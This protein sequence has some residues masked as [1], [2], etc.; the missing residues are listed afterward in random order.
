MTPSMRPGT[1]F[2]FAIAA[3]V[4]ASA[5]TPVETQGPQQRQASTAPMA[6]ADARTLL[7]QYCSTCHSDR[8]KAG[9]LLLTTLDVAQ[10][11]HDPEAWEK[12]SVRSG[13]E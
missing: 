10:V 3:C 2:T 8:I 7:D 12:S 11:A 4:L 9:G 13:Q 1:S 6:A 5:L